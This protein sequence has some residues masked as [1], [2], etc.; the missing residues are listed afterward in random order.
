MSE[1]ELSDDMKHTLWEAG[2]L[3]TKEKAFSSRGVTGTIKEWTYDQR[4]VFWGKLYGDVNE[5]WPDGTRIHT[6]LVN[7]VV[8]FGDS[9]IALTLNSVYLLPKSDQLVVSSEDET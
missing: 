8:D 4:G 1:E 2:I 6:S 3:K 5:R 7:H 9:F